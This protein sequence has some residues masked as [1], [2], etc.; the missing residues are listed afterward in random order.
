M[1]NGVMTIF[2]N[3][4]TMGDLEVAEVKDHQVVEEMVVE[5][6]HQ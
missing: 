5:I 2:L 6:H 4:K 3:L 1:Q